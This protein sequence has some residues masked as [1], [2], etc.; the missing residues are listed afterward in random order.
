MLKIK[1]D[2]YNTYLRG[3]A[4]KAASRIFDSLL[5]YPDL[6]LRHFSLEKSAK[7]NYYLLKDS[8][9]QTFLSKQFWINTKEI[10]IVREFPKYLYNRPDGLEMFSLNFSKIKTTQPKPYPDIV[11]FH[12]IAQW[13]DFSHFF[14][15]LP[16]KT[17]LVWT[18]HDMHPITGG[19]H[20]SNGCHKFESDCSLCPQ[21]GPYNKE[22]LAKL[23]LNVKIE[24]LKGRDVYVIS[25][26]KWLN[27]LVQKSRIFKNANLIDFIHYGLDHE[28]YYPLDK[29]NV[30]KELGLS[31]DDSEYVICFGADSIENNRKGFSE[32]ISAL[33]LLAEK[34]IKTTCV[35]FG[36]GQVLRS[37]K[38]NYV[39]FGEIN[40]EKYLA[41]IYNTADVFVMPSLEE[42]FGQTCLEAMLCGIPVVG[43]D[44][45]GI[46]DMIINNYTGLLT[47]KGNV[48]ELAKNINKL[49]YNKELRFKLGKNARQYAVHNFNINLQ[50]EKYYSLYNKI[51]CTK[52][53]TESFSFM[54]KKFGV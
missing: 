45:G 10:E 46:P 16:P 34:N 51:M 13:F 47:E 24:A 22:D 33:N 43:F 30:R 11:H 41:K 20:Y 15:K 2:H 7:K 3:G 53:Q 42:A 40:D 50:A 29:R 26:S 36:A 32:L 21:L 54:P 31:V 4:G 39:N 19:C 6:K 1:I 12:W 38:I 17:P 48:F 14:K 52:K 5:R 18:L 9:L 28:T 37:D 35:T 49:Y 8:R 44:T 25:D 23:N 27:G